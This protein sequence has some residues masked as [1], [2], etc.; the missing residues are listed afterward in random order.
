MC[1]G[2]I[3][4]CGHPCKDAFV[5]DVCVDECELEIDNSTVFLGIRLNFI[6]M[7]TRMRHVI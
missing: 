3:E 1:D 4:D 7:Q 5:C 2:A 6:A